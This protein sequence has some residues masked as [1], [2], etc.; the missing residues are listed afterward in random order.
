MSYLYR[1]SSSIS[2]DMN[3]RPGSS[4]SNTS[5]PSLD[6]SS[7]PTSLES[8]FD[9]AKTEAG[10]RD[11]CNTIG[12]D[13]DECFGRHPNILNGHSP[14][15]ISS[16][17]EATWPQP[18]AYPP[19]PDAVA[20]WEQ[21]HQ[22]QALGQLASRRARSTLTLYR[23]FQDEDPAN[24]HDKP[25]FAATNKDENSKKLVAN[26][27]MG[28]KSLK[29]LIPGLFPRAKTPVQTAL[30]KISTP[31]APT[32]RQPTRTLSKNKSRGHR[33]RE[34]RAA[35]VP[36]LPS[37]ATIS[38]LTT[39]PRP[40]LHSFTGFVEYANPPAIPA[41]YHYRLRAQLEA[42]DHYH[43]RLKAHLNPKF[44]EA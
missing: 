44:K 27:K 10:L 30:E 11:I 28:W 31:P 38:D 16:A 12:W 5:Y 6:S 25:L 20:A 22:A 36:P 19:P 18:P 3:S 24:D 23:N 1:T 17:S 7:R 41:H 14:P 2:S 40:R 9:A 32:N 43:Y 37:L 42:E 33:R 39:E 29:R 15:Q 21:R 26:R 13:Y 34:P 8:T 35:L 4:L